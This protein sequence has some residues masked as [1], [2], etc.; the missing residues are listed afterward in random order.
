MLYQAAM[1]ARCFNPQLKAFADRLKDNG[2]PHKLIIIA[3]ARKL[4]ILANAILKR[5]IPWINANA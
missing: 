1:A 4:L 2:K 5:K 3:V